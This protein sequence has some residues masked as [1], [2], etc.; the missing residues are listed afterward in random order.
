MGCKSTAEADDL[1]SKLQSSVDLAGTHRLFSAHLHPFTPFFKLST[2]TVKK[3]TA[4][5]S[6]SKPPEEHPHTIR[7]LAKQFLSFIH[8]S[9]SL[10]PKRLSE[11]PKIPHDSALELFDSYRLCLDC[12]ELIAPELAGKPHSVHVQRIRYIHCLERWELYKEAEA[13]GFVV[14][15][16]LSAV[17]GGG[18]KGKSRKSKERLVPELDEKSVDQEVAAIVLEVVVTLVKCASKRRSKVGAD[19][20]RVISLVNESEPWFK[21]LDAKDYEKF[22]C[23]LETNLHIIA[24]FLVAEMKC[25]GVDLICEFSMVTFREYKKSHAHDQVY[26]V[27]LK[28]CSSLFSQ[29]D[30]LSSDIILDVLTHVL[31]I[32]ADECKVGVEETTPG[33][34]ELVCYCANKCHSS[35]VSLCDPVAEHLSRLADTFRADFPFITSVLTLYASGLLASSSHDQSK[36]KDIEKCRNTLPRYA[37]QNFL[38][39]KKQC[40]QMAASINLLNDHSDIGGKVKN[41]QHKESSHGPYWEALKFFC[42][43]LADS[44]Y[45]NRKEILSE[46]ESS[47]DDLNIIQYAFHEFCNIFLQCLSA[48]EK[49]RETSGDNHRVISVVAV[50]ALMLSL[51]TNQYI[52]EST[53]LVKQVISAEWVSVKRLKYLYV[54]LNNLAVIFTRKKRPKEAIKAL[55]LCC[56]ASWNYVAYLSRMHVEKSHVSCDDLSEKAIAEFIMEASQKV[57][58][59]LQ[60]NQESNFKINGIIKKSLICWSVSENLIATVPTPVSLIKEWV[61]VQYLMLK[62]A[63]TEHGMMLY[64]LLSSCKE[65]SKKT[66]GKILEEELLSYETQSYLNPRYCLRMRLQ[67]IDILLEEF[68]IA[69]DSNLKKSRILIEKGKVLRVHGLAR[70]DECVQCLSD[71]ISTLKLIY[72]A[73]KSCSSRVHQLLIHAYLLHA[74]CTQEASPNS[75]VL[76]PK[77]DFLNDIHAALDL[78]LSSD[79]GHADEQY[80]DMLFLWYQLIDF[81]SIKGYLEIHPRLYDVV[82]KLFNEKNFPL[83]KTISELWKNRR[84]SH[85]LCA[86]PVNH[87]FIDTFAKH[88]SQF[89]TSTKFW[90]TCMEELK[91]L[92]VGFHHINTEIKQAASCLISSVP[93]SSSFFRL[94]NL[95]YD[96]SARLV[97]SGHMIEAL[98]YAKEAH[99]LR[100]KLLKQ[101][102][103]YSVEKMTETFDEDG[104]I[105]EKTY[106]GIQTFKVA[107]SLVAKG[108]DYEGCTLTPWNVLSCY[109]ESLLQVGMIHEILGNVLDAEM[110]LR[111][112]RN[113]SRIQGLPHF[114]V[115]FSVMLGKLYRKQKL[116]NVAEKELSSAK[117]TLASNVDVVSCKRC[118][119]MLESSINQ[120]IGDLFLSRFSSTG[121]SPSM[122]MLVDA[123]S[124]YKLALDKLNVF[125]WRTS[126]S[127]SEE[128]RLEQVISRESPLSSCVINPPKANDTLSNAK[129]ETKIEPRRSR[130]TKKEVKPASQIQE[131]VCNRNRRITRSTLR[132]L[133]KTEEIVSADRHNAPTAGSA[134]D[135]LSTA[136]V[137]SEHNVAS[138][139][140]ECSAAD[141]RNGISSLCNKMKC[142]HCLYT[143]AVDCSTLNN[144]IHMN[145]ELVYRSLCLRLLVSIGKFSGICGNVH[146]AQEI[147][148]ESLSVLR[149]KS[150]CSNCSSDSLIFLIES[151]GKHFPG[152][153][154]AVQRASLLYYICWFTLKSYPHQGTGNICCELSCIGTVKIVSLLKMSF[155]L[156]R[157][158]PLLFKK[159][160]RLLA[161]VYVLSTSLKQF[162]L[163][164]GEEGSESQWASFF[165]QASLGTDLNQQIISGMVQKK[166]SQSATNSEDSSL[167]N[168]ISTIL[169]LAGSIRTAPES[170]EDLEEFVLRFFQ[171][172]PSIPVICISLVSGSD[173]SLFRELLHWSHNVRAFILLSHL[174]SDNQHVILLPVYET[175]EASDDD[176]SSSSVVFNWKDFDKQWKCPWVSTVIDEIAPVFRHVLER[177]YYSSSEHFLEYIKKNTSL[178][179]RQRNR[180]DQCLSKFLQDMEDLWLGTW[181]YLLLGEWPDCSHLDTIEKNLFE[182]E[183]HL[184]Q[185]V[186]TKKCYVGQG[187]EASSSEF[188]SKMHTLFKRM[189]EMSDNFDED[190]GITRKPIILVLDFDVQMLP[191]ENLP[192]LRNQE[193]YRMPSVGSIFA[194]LDR[195]CQNE[196]QFET[197]IPAFPSIDPLD[198]YYLLNPD[199]DLRT[200][201]LEFESWFKDQNIEGKI[202]TVPTVQEL[203]L[204]LKN[205]DL[206]VYCGHG[207]GTQYIP[208]HQI[209]KLDT[210][211]ATLLLGCSSGSLYLKGCYLPEGAPISYILAG[212]PVIVANLWEVTD[213]D[214]DRFGKAMLNAWLRERSA[215]S[216]KCDQ[217]IVPNKS[218]KCSHRP[219]IGSFMGQ[220]RDA[221]TL[222]FLIGASPVCYG[223]PT[224][225]IKRKKR[226]A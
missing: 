123:K 204:A 2:A 198:S 203:S 51:K 195:C 201:Q 208:G 218:K 96:S 70:L 63:D 183:E 132:S 205:H 95:Y 5:S 18:L 167:S 171:G 164:P 207:S 32:M 172:L 3:T 197:N 184:L 76:S 175:L 115:S 141:F 48:T 44:I 38:N 163:S 74:L 143:E 98:A 100:S 209:E 91:P 196:E 6:K 187:S 113:I 93:Q 210:C 99:S 212:S 87:M 16:S 116:W 149:K 180:L 142:W 57:A 49:E 26:K 7:S 138:S 106:Y 176:A 80:E 146:E 147:L 23:F 131:V 72:G 137:G 11:T 28:I 34:L 102:F 170:Y 105:I 27:A 220:A 155:I 78:Y 13:E 45:F 224:G 92:I 166:Q 4:K 110:L 67:I 22:H 30:E 129:A 122:K 104:R 173:A 73:K 213:K 192:I 217:C 69:K 157:E 29:I 148:L 194:T 185:L 158:V 81:L 159:I 188:E 54:S 119:C 75:M 136:A 1:L 189:L 108:C 94:S 56:K 134:T 101:N 223:V 66:L 152:D 117:K 126:N 97:S 61:K 103:E 71:A 36:G 90:R 179:W 31:D 77:S 124:F 202:G 47:W 186:V 226:T 43:S 37:L 182:D 225:I 156:C 20:W 17:V 53:L 199:G 215:A 109:L 127:T 46:A 14:L 35:T 150:S 219:R 59:L 154:L 68:Y 21:I 168:S 211:A 114:E 161:G 133:V 200:T 25:F 9:L 174:S 151:I 62:D 107:D 39:N 10:L 160:C 130:R 121:E 15:Q 64:S 40:Q 89:S 139:E 177:N 145:W 85:G 52:K 118:L 41:S 178:W 42:Q 214:I 135:H 190:E 181:K 169:D 79:H 144:F 140:S 120:Q 84:L 112:G 82:M 24:L 162:S 86:S 165:H 153:A 12:L 128:A 55:K 50:A 8:K 206:F 83:A 191:W 111:W 125:N 19:Y 60:L 216:S 58:F 65:I 221:C 193:V 88:Q 222:G 33:F